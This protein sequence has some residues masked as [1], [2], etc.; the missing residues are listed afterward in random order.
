MR[1]ALALIAACLTLA[2]LAAGDLGTLA[3]ET[4][5]P[6]ARLNAVQSA[7]PPRSENCLAPADLREAVA[8]RRVIEPVAAI[9]A[10]R[11]V[12]PRADIQR[13]S[14]CRHEDGLVYMLT[15]LRRDGHFVHVMVDAKTGQV[16]G[17]Y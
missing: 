11:T 14:L 17:Q 10:A 7:P 8:E 16:A 4:A 13:A 6:G 9:R 15:A 2:A 1:Y 12:I 3:E 5:Q